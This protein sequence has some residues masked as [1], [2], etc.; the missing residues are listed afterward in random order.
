MCENREKKTWKWGIVICILYLLKHFPS[1]VLSKVGYSM[2]TLN[3][4]VELWG[5]RPI[6]LIPS[7]SFLFIDSKQ[8]EIIYSNS[9]KKEFLCTMQGIPVIQYKHIIK[10]NIYLFYILILNT[11]NTLHSTLI[12]NFFQFIFKF[13]QTRGR[14]F[15]Q[16]TSKNLTK[17]VQ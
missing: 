12:I 15:M 11:L 2:N 14:E 13:L 16:N 1:R 7:F 17:L 6:M 3:L 8:L 10:Y 9:L 4:D 5:F